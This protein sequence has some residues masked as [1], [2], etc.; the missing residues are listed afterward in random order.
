MEH[1]L[2]PNTREAGHSTRPAYTS[3]AH[4]ALL[5]M[6]G[7]LLILTGCQEDRPPER[8]VQPNEP[9]AY[10]EPAATLAPRHPDDPVEALAEFY[11]WYTIYPGSPLDRHSYRTNEFLRPYLTAKLVQKVD[12]TLANLGERSGYDPFLCGQALPTRLE[13]EL[14]EREGDRA[15]V[16]VHHYE[17]GSS[18][19]D[20]MLVEMVRSSGHWRIDSTLCRLPDEQAKHLGSVPSVAPPV[21]EPEEASTPFPATWFTYRSSHDFRIAYPAGWTIVE[22]WVSEPFD[23]D[24]IDGYVSFRGPDRSVPVALVLST[25]SMADFRLVFPEP[26]GESRMRVINGYEVLFEEH[27][28]GEQYAIFLHPD[29]DQQRVALRVIARGSTLDAGTRAII[30]R[31]LASLTFVD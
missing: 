26:E 12:Q 6:F 27:F 4:V 28:D 10:R 20:S 15:S 7:L 24:P 17:N 8:A 1:A 9:I 18:T 11:H 21:E 14:A 16:I 22:D 25:G 3:S 2:R 5:L 30:D 19:P 13:Y 23:A 31:M 29:D